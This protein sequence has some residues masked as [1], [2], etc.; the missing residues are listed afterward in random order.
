MDRNTL[1]HLI[2]DLDNALPP[3][4][5]ELESS[6]EAR[7]RLANAY[8]N[9]L[10]ARDVLRAECPDYLAVVVAEDAELREGATLALPRRKRARRLDR[11]ARIAGALK[12]TREEI[13]EDLVELRSEALRSLARDAG[14]TP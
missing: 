9:V 2:L 13:L 6:P 12:R 4:L 1:A 10:H 5:A 7:A 3:I 8:S 14:D 11:I